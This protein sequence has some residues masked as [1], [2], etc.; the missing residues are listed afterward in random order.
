MTV[1]IVHLPV[2]PTDHHVATHKSII[3]TGA[4]GG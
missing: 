3:Q 4:Q 1:I 2:M